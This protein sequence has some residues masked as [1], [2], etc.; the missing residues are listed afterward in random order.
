MAELGDATNIIY[1]IVRSRQR[2]LLEALKKARH[3][4]LM[5]AAYAKTESGPVWVEGGEGYNAIKTATAAIEVAEI[6]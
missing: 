6:S 5:A 4:M 3:V 2:P 1:A